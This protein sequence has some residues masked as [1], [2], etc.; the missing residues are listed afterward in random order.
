[1]FHVSFADKFSARGIVS[2]PVESTS[3]HMLLTLKLI[4]QEYRKLNET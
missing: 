3:P 4:I 2:S 1:V